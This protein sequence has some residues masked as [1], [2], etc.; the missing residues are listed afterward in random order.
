MDTVTISF[1]IT[2]IYKIDTKLQDGLFLA[3]V[4]WQLIN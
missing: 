1:L 2:L 4:K 3:K